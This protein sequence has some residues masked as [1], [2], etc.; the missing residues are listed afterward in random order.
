MAEAGKEKGEKAGQKSKRA[1]KCQKVPKSEGRA[2]GAFASPK[3][4]GLHLLAAG[5][6]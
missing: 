5:G 2:L 6:V 3:K 4:S 1:K